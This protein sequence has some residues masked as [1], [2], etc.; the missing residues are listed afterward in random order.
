MQLK[1]RWKQ[2]YSSEAKERMRKQRTIAL[3]QTLNR[4]HQKKQH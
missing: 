2:D 4:F 3:G 1:I